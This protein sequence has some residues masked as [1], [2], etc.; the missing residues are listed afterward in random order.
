MSWPWLSCELDDVTAEAH[1]RSDDGEREIPWSTLG[2]QSF[3]PFLIPL[4][5]AILSFVGAELG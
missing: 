1:Q 2:Y 5:Q 3:V 4:R